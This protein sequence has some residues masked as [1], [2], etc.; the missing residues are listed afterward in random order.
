MDA[1]AKKKFGSNIPS[2]SELEQ[3]TKLA[4]INTNPAMDHMAPLPENIIPG[5]KLNKT[6]NYAYQINYESYCT[7]A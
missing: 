4:L 1:I 5:K 3:R 2:V 7:D 6:K